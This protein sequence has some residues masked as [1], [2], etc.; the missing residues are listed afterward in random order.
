[1]FQF[2]AV[3]FEQG[4]RGCNDI[5]TRYEAF[6]NFW[7]IILFFVVHALPETKL[8]Q[9]MNIIFTSEGGIGEVIKEI[10]FFLEDISLNFACILGGTIKA[11]V[12]ND[13]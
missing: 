12:S 8:I 6:K 4:T 3:Y 13:Y 7:I 1:M 5:F 9:V 11:W 2:S 10:D